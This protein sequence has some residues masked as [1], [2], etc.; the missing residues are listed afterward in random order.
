[1]VK[2][3]NAEHRSGFNESGRAVAILAAG[4]RIVAWM[5]MGAD[6]RGTIGDYGSF[7]YAHRSNNAG[8]DTALRYEVDPNQAVLAI[9]HQYIEQFPV[10]IGIKLLASK[11]KNLPGIAENFPVAKKR[12]VTHQ[13]YSLSWDT[14]VH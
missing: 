10:C 3:A 9:Q 2:D 7:I 11:F 6:N 12:T 1:M 4:R 13:R 5:V 8:A 14:V